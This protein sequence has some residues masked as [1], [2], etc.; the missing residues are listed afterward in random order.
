MRA[1]YDSTSPRDVTRPAAM[2]SLEI[3]D[4]QLVD[5]EELQDR[6]RLRLGRRLAL[7][8]RS[9]DAQQN[10]QRSDQTLVKACR[11]LA[12]YSVVSAPSVALDV[13]VAALDSTPPD[14]S[15]P[16]SERTQNSQ[17]HFH[18]LRDRRGRRLRL[19][20]DRSR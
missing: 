17:R 6:R 16:R 14:V 8:L 7:P 11:I 2:R 9:S 10:Q 3:D 18:R 12:V 4:R 1:R 20:A 15:I 13:V 5:L 19:L